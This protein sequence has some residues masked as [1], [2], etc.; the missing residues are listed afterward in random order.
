MSVRTNN[1][2]LSRADAFTPG[3]TTTY[4][5]NQ[6]YAQAPYGYGAQGPYGAQSGPN[7]P[8]QVTG[9]MTI[10]DVITKTA[11]LM[12]VIV[13][14]AGL[15]WLLLPAQLLAPVAV[16]GSI[17]TAITVWMV[18]LRREL[19]VA[20]VFVYA[21]V[22]GLV[23][24]A[25][26]KLFEYMYPGIVLQ[27]VVGTVIS[28]FVVLGAYKYLNARVRGRL[29]QIVTVSIIAYAVF[30]LLSLVLTLFGVNTGAF[31]IGAG[32]GPF[33]WL[34]A[35]IGVVLSAASLLMDFD[36]IEN[37][38]RMG[39]PEKESWRGAFGLITSLVW[40]YT[41]LLRILSFFRN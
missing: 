23:L 13:A 19:P 25:F 30:A 11:T 39:A 41:Q 36:A 2:I 1:P 5:P 37:G 12:L 14:G 10:D 7:M 34:M 40:M 26:S 29:A 27:A 21:G 15:V 18:A 4:A 32:A 22:E 17:V 24:G 6:G 38:V 8:Q 33:A 28:A 9:R 3:Y 31:A 35:G 20:G 16:I